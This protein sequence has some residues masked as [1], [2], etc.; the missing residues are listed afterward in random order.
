MLKHYLVIAL[1]NL[2]RSPFVAAVNVVALSLGIATFV[3][4]YA[5]VAFWSSADKQFANSDRIY[6]LTTSATIL[7][8]DFSFEDEPHVPPQMAG[9]L[10]D[11]LPAAEAIARATV[12]N[13]E[14]MVST[15]DRAMRLFGVAVD[16]DFLRIFDLPFVAGDPRHALDA[17][18]SVVITSEYATKL[19]GA[20]DP[21]GKRLRLANSI[22][23][24]VTGVMDAVP[25]PSHMGPLSAFRPQAPQ[26]PPCAGR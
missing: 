25:E 4:A 19:F 26:G 10:E 8:L 23:T 22:D 17:P 7:G 3:A 15:G 5:V 9:Y 16:S 18:R 13:E 20:E 12:M 24:T 11:E 2:R 14:S 1:V 6:A 21:I